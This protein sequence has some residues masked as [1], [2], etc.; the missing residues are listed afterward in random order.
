MAR[1]AATDGARDYLYTCSRSSR[2]GVTTA[3][4]AVGAATAALATTRY[5]LRRR[6]AITFRDRT[7]LITGGSR[8]LGLVLARQFA[9]EGARL[10]LVARDADQLARARDELTARGAEVLI[11]PCDVRQQ[12]DVVRAVDAVVGVFGCLD[13]LVNNAGIIDVG[14]VDHVTMDDFADA[15]ATHFW[16]PLHTIV[17]ALPHMRRCGARRIVNISSIGGKIAVPHLLPYSAS[18]F[19]LAG[20]SSGLAVELVRDGF[21]VTTVFPGLMRT[22]STYN[23]RFKGHHR[24]EFAWFH[25]A[26]ALP[27]VSVAAERAAA[28]IVDACRCGDPELI[29]GV[30]ARMA[31]VASAL[32]PATFAHVLALVNRVLPPPA[33]GTGDRTRTGWQSSSAAVPSLVTKLADR[34]TLDNNEIPR[35]GG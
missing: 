13:V 11:V 35:H 15:M 25:T 12:P 14:P 27:G 4:A 26:D 1:H 10:A 23:A 19:A 18:K 30:P 3:L 9:A 16:G 32:L 31:T 20:L 17:A 8:G 28:Q 21:R 7:V 2:E 24:Q 33:E 6:R 29:I 22:G 5:L 34:A